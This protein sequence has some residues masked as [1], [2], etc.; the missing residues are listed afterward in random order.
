M[1]RFVLTSLIYVALIFIAPGFVLIE[2]LA[3]STIALAALHAALYAL[4][5]T[6][7]QWGV[8]L[9]AFL[10]KYEPREPLWFTRLRH[11]TAL[12]G[13]GWLNFASL[14]LIGAASL[15][16]GAHLAEPWCVWFLV[17]AV[18]LALLDFD[19]EPLQ[20]EWADGL[21]TPCVSFDAIPEA[22]AGSEYKEVI[23]EWRPLGSGAEN[24]DTRETKFLVSEHEY[25]AVRT[26]DRY[27]TS[28]VEEYA[29]YVAEGCHAN[30]ILR[31]ARFVREQMSV[32][33]KMDRLGEIFTVVA[34]TR[35]IPYAYDEETRNV[36]EW[37]D[38]PV[39]L[40]YDQ[41]GDCE[42]HGIFAAAVLHVLGHDVGLFYLRL[43]DC[44]HLALACQ[45]NEANGPFVK[46]D[47]LG[48]PYFYIETV[49]TNPGHLLGDMPP[50]FVAELKE[51][52]LILV[53]RT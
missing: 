25:A 6:L 5:F 24:V 12:R 15:S 52:R 53:K 49:S 44:G 32:P 17:A 36:S 18:A 9:A 46:V 2:S 23:I 35:G 30:S 26:L 21:P 50:S 27:P 3:R 42:D 10:F 47:A 43:E 22:D 14:A 37:A 13:Y 19:D 39:E 16:L 11:A 8:L 29:R 40:L 45:T 28:P 7:V 4:L 31:V 51:M 33:G 38:F 20:L 41:A 1:P 34:I 48:R